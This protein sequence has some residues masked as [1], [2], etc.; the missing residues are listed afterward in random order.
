MQLNKK[1]TTCNLVVTMTG[2]MLNL[3]L[4]LHFSRI[5]QQFHAIGLSSAADIDAWR[6]RDISLQ[7]AERD[8]DPDGGRGVD[9]WGEASWTR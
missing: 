9:P 6:S 3:Q 2:G 8:A 1:I 4:V 7:P 5:R